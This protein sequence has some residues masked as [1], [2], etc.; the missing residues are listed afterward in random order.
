MYRGRGHRNNRKNTWKPE[1]CREQMVAL[2]K[3]LQ[4]QRKLQEEGDNFDKQLELM[5][6]Q[7]EKG[8]ERAEVD[9]QDEEALCR[10]KNYSINRISKK[11]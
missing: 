4:K 6:T 1:A 2:N 10:K 8:M 5:A 9:E 3:K 7:W 11:R